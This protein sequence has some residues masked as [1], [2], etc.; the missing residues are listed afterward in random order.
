M[1]DYTLEMAKIEERIFKVSEFNEFINIY[2]SSVGEVVVEGE[3]AEIKVSQN[4]WLFLTVKDDTSSLDVFAITYQIS[5]YSVLEAGMMVHIYGV[6]RLYQKT[7]KFSLYAT[8]IV[9]AGEGAL[10]LAFEKLKEKL[11]REGLFDEAR[12]RKITPFPEKIGLI[13]APSSRAF[14]DFAKVLRERIGSIK[15][16]FYPVLVQGKDSVDSI[17]SAF[18]YFNQKMPELDALVLVRGGGS[19]EDLQ[20]F[21]D[22][23]LARAIFSSKIPVVCGVGHEDDVTIADLVSDLR[24]STPSNA[25]ELL[26][27]TRSEIWNNVNY[28]LKVMDNFIRRS[29]ADTKNE[30]KKYV[31]ILEKAISYQIHLTTRAKDKMLGQFNL[32]K[33]RILNLRKEN[34]TLKKRLY[35]ACNYLFLKQKEI[36]LS[37]IKYLRCFDIRKTLARGFSLTFDEKGRILRSIK[38]VSKNSLITTNLVDGK[39]ASEV[40]KLEKL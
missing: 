16:Y 30:L 26:V 3:I 9:P 38:N 36:T 10:R 1:C 14:S 33:S 29:L 27:R 23:R 28:R 24:A 2:L 21:N 37:L 6:P 34:E 7:G 12:K 31:S 5:G 18:N 40:L 22:E 8:K 4:K 13:T 19:L 15:I 32:L 11:F 35:N 17:I 25:A 20:S 39:I